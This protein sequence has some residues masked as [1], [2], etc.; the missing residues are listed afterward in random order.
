MATAAA[1]DDREA[2]LDRLGER[3]LRRVNE[4]GGTAMWSGRRGLRQKFKSNERQL[5]D[6]A[7][8]RLVDRG[9]VTYDGDA[10]KVV[11]V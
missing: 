8:S 9:A 5:A 4:A 3:I 1:V 6:I 2:R 10:N 11:R 7:L